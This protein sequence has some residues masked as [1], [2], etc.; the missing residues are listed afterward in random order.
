MSKMKKPIAISDNFSGV[1]EVIIMKSG[2]I[3][4]RFVLFIVRELE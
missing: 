2:Y 4:A 1:L 3:F